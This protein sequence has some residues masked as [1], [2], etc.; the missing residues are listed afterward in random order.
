MTGEELN[1]FQIAVR[2]L[3]LA[4]LF[5]YA[6]I[7]GVRLLGRVAGL[8]RRGPRVVRLRKYRALVRQRD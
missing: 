6:A 3:F 4:A 1:W 2:V 8:F 5:A 7:V